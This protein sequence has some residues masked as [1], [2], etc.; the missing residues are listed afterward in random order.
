MKKERVSETVY[1]ITKLFN[2]FNYDVSLKEFGLKEALFNKVVRQY[3]KLRFT[4]KYASRREQ[5]NVLTT[6]LTHAIVNALVKD[7]L[8]IK[9]KTPINLLSKTVYF[10]T[11]ELER[12]IRNPTYNYDNKAGYV[13]LTPI[14]HPTD[15]KIECRLLEIRDKKIKRSFDRI[16]FQVLGKKRHYIAIREKVV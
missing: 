16:A 11:S 7:H 3:F 8:V 13:E 10:L 6:T 14:D 12:F 2:K 9:N 4:T 1:D 5:R 15:A